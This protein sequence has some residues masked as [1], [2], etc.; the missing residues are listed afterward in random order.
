MNT[1]ADRKKT[2][3]SD[4]LKNETSLFLNDDVKIDDLA[5]NVRIS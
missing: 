1:Y 3:K 5:E 4:L 2:S